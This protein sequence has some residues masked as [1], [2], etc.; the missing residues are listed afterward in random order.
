MART[1]RVPGVGHE[2]TDASH[3]LA[4][5]RARR[6]R[7]RHRPAEQRD[8]RPNRHVGRGL[9]GQSGLAWDWPLSLTLDVAVGD[10]VTVGNL[11]N[12]RPPAQGQKKPGGRQ[13]TSGRT[14]R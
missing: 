1:A 7:P 4:L 14:G 11:R 8:P 5:L 6:E 3:R 2:Y 12:G 10:T 13:S 9:H